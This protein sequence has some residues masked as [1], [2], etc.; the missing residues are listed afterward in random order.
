MWLC[1]N[2]SFVSIV[3]KGDKPG[4]L[5]VRARRSGDIEKVFPGA[6]VKRTPGN[7]YLFRAYVNRKVVAQT[8]ADRL[9][10][11]DYSNFKGSTK[12]KRLHDAYMRVW[13]IMGDLQPGGPYS[14]GST[15]GQGALL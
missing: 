1:F 14:H 4:F 12:D 13:G 5:C 15:R 11:L 8:V 9:L 7:D 6:D 3:D 10:D 2:N